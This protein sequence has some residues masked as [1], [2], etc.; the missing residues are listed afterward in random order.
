MLAR[1]RLLLTWILMAAVPVQGFAAGS[2]LLCVAATHEVAA[3][4]AQAGAQLQHDHTTHTHDAADAD[5]KSIA[6]ATVADAQHQC[7]LCAACCHSVG[8][9][10]LPSMWQGAS[11]PQADLT[12]P[13]M[14]IPSHAPPLPDKPPRA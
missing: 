8:I 12:D 11:A 4:A 1:L 3:H 10:Q 5:T 14:R 9:T 2:M 6:H 7:S 13:F